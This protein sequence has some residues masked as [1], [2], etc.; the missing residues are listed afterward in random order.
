M[1]LEDFPKIESEK[2][3]TRGELLEEFKSSLEK[4]GIEGVNIEMEDNI[5]KMEQKCGEGF[6]GIG[7]DGKFWMC[8][9]QGEEA[10]SNP[11][12]N[13]F[14]YNEN[15]LASIDSKFPGVIFEEIG[16]GK[17]KIQIDSDHPAIA[18]ANLLGDKEIQLRGINGW[19]NADPFKFNE[20]TGKW[21][22]EFDWNGKFKECKIMIRDVEEKEGEKVTKPMDID[23]NGNYGEGAK[24]IMKIDLGEEN[25]EE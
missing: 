17:I 23:W 7:Y 9:G 11:V 20:G 6:R 15:T 2:G 10:K 14:Q 13:E 3:K 16:E 5:L 1:S 12:A 4:Y 25:K 19:G 18:I 24:Q 21:E 8:L 22:A